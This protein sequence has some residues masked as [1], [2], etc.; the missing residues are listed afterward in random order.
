MSRDPQD[1]PAGVDDVAEREVRR[2]GRELAGLGRTGEG[3]APARGVELLGRVG[4]VGDGLVHVLIGVLAVQV[5]VTGGGQADQQGAVATLAAQPFGFVAIAVGVLGLAAFAVWQGVAAA[6]G[7]RWLSG[8]QRMQRRIGAGAHA[9]GVAFVALIGVQLLVT[10]S[11]GTS[12][13]GSQQTTA[14]LLA[15]PGGRVIVAAV[16]L[17]IAV[18]AVA[19]AWTGVTR[20]FLDDID[21]ARLP[22]AVRTPARWLG[23]AGYVLRAIA[24]AVMAVL[25][26]VA[27]VHADPGAAGGLDGALKTLA[28]QPYGPVLL[29]VVALGFVAFG[30]FNLVEARARTI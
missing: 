20:S 26:G 11:S 28:A 8:G 27:S 3:E 16:A 25:F 22:A 21:E 1:E 18:V 19:T 29:L 15:L 2:A 10:G 13:G 17:V 4:L 5:A 12:T 23:V 14:G 9:G 24:F 6:T 30:L 7:F